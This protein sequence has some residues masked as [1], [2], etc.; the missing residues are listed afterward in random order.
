M[1]LSQ[2]TPGLTLESLT[3]RVGEGP[4]DIEFLPGCEVL[5]RYPL[6]GMRA[7]LNR[8][9]H[10]QGDRETA[11]LT[12][13]YTPFEAHNL[14][15]EQSNYFDEQG[16][17]RLSAR[18]AG[19]YKSVDTLFVTSAFVHEIFCLLE[20]EL[21]PVKTDLQKHAALVGAYLHR[22]TLDELERILAHAKVS[23][24]ASMNLGNSDQLKARNDFDAMIEQAVDR[25]L[26]LDAE[27]IQR[28]F[29]EN[30]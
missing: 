28:I 10:N 17:A 9:Q 8:A 6:P 22:F 2:T 14:T 4:V 26:T 27:P 20:G 19:A 1:S 16:V 25:A 5:E 24:Y 3:A 18:E 29:A 11:V 15:L 7:R 13:D 21:P 12:V 30:R 23:L